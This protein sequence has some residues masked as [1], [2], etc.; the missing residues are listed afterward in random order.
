MS[1]TGKRSQNVWCSNRSNGSK[2]SVK[3]TALNTSVFLNQPNKVMIV[4]VNLASSVLLT[5]EKRC[6]FE[7]GRNATE[8]WFW[9]QNASCEMPSCSHWHCPQSGSDSAFSLT[10]KSI[11]SR[12]SVGETHGTWI[13]SF[14]G[15]GHQGRRH[16]SITAWEM[17][18]RLLKPEIQKWFYDC[19]DC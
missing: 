15:S 1:D 5:A 18:Q 9:T 7:I 4:G 10:R 3:R 11:R 19:S 8:K 12:L 13:L 2:R 14:S 6:I 16:A 17:K